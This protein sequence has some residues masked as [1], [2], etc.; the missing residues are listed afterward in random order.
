MIDR[1]KLLKEAQKLSDSIFFDYSSEL[2]IAKDVWQS[3]CKDELFPEKIKK[4]NFPWKLPTW[5]CNLDKN[6][7]IEPFTNYSVLATDGSQIY[8]DRHQGT[9]CFLIN[10]GSVLLDYSDN[11]KAKLES[12]PYIYDINVNGNDNSSVEIVDC[13]RQ[14]LE[15][16]TGFEICNSLKNPPLFLFDGSIIF[17]HLESKS[18]STRDEY[19]SKYLGILHQFYKNKY[20]IAG[21]ISLPKSKEL[22]NLIRSKLYLQQQNKSVDHIVDSH[23]AS[24][25]LNQFQRTILFKNHSPIVE[26][27][28]K[29]LSPYF[30]YLDVGQEIVRIEIPEWIAQDDEKLMM[31]SRIVVDQ[32]IKGYGYPVCLAEAHEQA[33]V[34]GVDRDFFYH[35]L[36]KISLNYKQQILLSQKSY[37]KRRIGF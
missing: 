19:L 10:I 16:K 2:N 27:Y 29:H 25:F 12:E 4:E 22:V 18:A 6:Y 14:Y 33:V 5:N 28:P 31:I 32:C 3:I 26:N 9:M 35:I 21:Y 34:K 36:K 30:F 17:W 13:Q 8:P 1:T 7:N 15:F 37:K 11:S 20:L 23:V 24:F